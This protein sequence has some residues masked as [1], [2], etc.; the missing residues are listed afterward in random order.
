MDIS[1]QI[2]IQNDISFINREIERNLNFIQNEN[3]IYQLIK[4]FSGGFSEEF[5]TSIQ[6]LSNQNERYVN[7]LHRIDDRLKETDKEDYKAI[8]NN[9]KVSILEGYKI[10][11]K[12]YIGAIEEYNKIYNTLN[13]D[14]GLLDVIQK[15]KSFIEGL[16]NNMI[17]IGY[18]FTIGSVILK[19]VIHLIFTDRDKDKD[20]E[21]IN[22]LENYVK[23][24]FTVL[25]PFI[26]D[27]REVDI[28][29]VK[30][31]P[32]LFEGLINQSEPFFLEFL[33]EESRD[34]DYFFMLELRHTELQEINNYINHHTQLYEGNFKS[35]LYDALENYRDLLQ[36]K[37]IRKVEKWLKDN[38]DKNFQTIDIKIPK[39]KVRRKDDTFTSLSAE[40]TAILFHY[41]KTKKVILN[42]KNLQ[43]DTEIAKAIKILTGYSDNTIRQNLTK[44]KQKEEIS[45]DD[46]IVTQ[47]ILKEIITLINKD[48]EAI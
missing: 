21:I 20:D 10:N 23:P 16:F 30:F 29:H 47:K 42:D 41:L 25:I 8:L 45:K 48:L 36:D 27:K 6:A 2:Y 5:N 32:K 3:I 44:S 9:R 24:F 39:I 38:S 26:R 34:F 4:S 28:N 33:N 31:N 15:V 14:D 7:L 19:E 35:F 18:D 11:R 12:K 40:Q 37:Q 17:L 46:L 22:H 43:P 1:K 13:N